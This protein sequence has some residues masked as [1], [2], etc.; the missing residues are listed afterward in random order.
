VIRCFNEEAHLGNL[1]EAVEAQRGVD[2]E[3]IVVD[4]GSTD[5]SV[6]IAKAAGA[7]IL[8]I[9]PDEF[10]FGRSL[11]IGCAAATGEFIAM[12]SAHVV[13]H[14]TDWLRQLL[15]PFEN[16]QVAKTYGRQVG[17]WSS[18]FSEHEVLAKQFPADSNF[19]QAVPFCNNANSAIRSDLWRRNHYDEALS[20]LEDLAWGKWAIENDFLLAYNAAAVV[21]HIHHE[22]PSQILNRY[23]R[24]AIALKRIL[25]DSH[26]SFLKFAKLMCQNILNDEVRA[27]RAGKFWR[28][29]WEIVMFRTM[30]Y[31]G[32]FTGLNSRSDLTDEM[33]MRFYYPR[34]FGKVQ[35]LKSRFLRSRA[36]DEVRNAGGDRSLT[37][38]GALGTGAGEELQDIS[39]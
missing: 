10:T 32:T 12:A 1:L 22:A 37:H 29:A 24:E 17:H 8:E 4:S 27:L 14:R 15:Q 9:S 11:N 13:P 31:W 2:A 7:K 34:E 36:Q 6:S 30:Q 16:P 19:S 33:L 35:R 25:P 21:S 38:E 28:Y 3:V 5:R 23:R 26:M 18:R 20:G 39:R